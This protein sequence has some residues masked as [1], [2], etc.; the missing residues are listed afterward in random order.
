MMDKKLSYFGEN[1]LILFQAEHPYNLD[2]TR[3]ERP[4]ARVIAAAQRHVDEFDGKRDGM[5]QLRDKAY[6]YDRFRTVLAEEGVLF[7]QGKPV[8][9][10][11]PAAVQD[12]LRQEGFYERYG[13]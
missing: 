11:I 7:S 2:G 5:G 6:E 12:R 3:C 10:G 4:S 8:I 13:Y 9:H 1:C